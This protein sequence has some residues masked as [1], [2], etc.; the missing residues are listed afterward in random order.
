M[1]AIDPVLAE[2]GL[3]GIAFSQFKDQMT[4]YRDV[5]GEV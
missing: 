1:T 5:S 4:N 2:I 3:V